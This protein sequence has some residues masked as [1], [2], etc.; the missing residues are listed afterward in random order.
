M[1]IEV[2]KRENGRVSFVEAEALA[3]FEHNGFK[4]AVVDARGHHDL[5]D[6]K[7]RHMVVN[8]ETGRR[9]SY[10]EH[11]TDIIK[12]A[13]EKIDKHIADL[14]PAVEIGR[15][16]KSKIGRRVVSYPEAIEAYYQVACECKTHWPPNFV[17]E[18]GLMAL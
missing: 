12:L 9:V 15:L 2:F 13:T 14:K 8:V 3:Q 11:P 17:V 4:F 5:E 7:Y 10:G 6:P 18:I 1:T 16:F